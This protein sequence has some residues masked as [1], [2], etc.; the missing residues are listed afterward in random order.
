M[1]LIFE[2]EILKKE[3]RANK[4]NKLYISG[5]KSFQ[6]F[7]E[8]ASIIQSVFETAR[9]IFCLKKNNGIFTFVSTIF[10]QKLLEATW[11]TGIA[12]DGSFDC[13]TMFG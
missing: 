2:N 1:P 9:Q 6:R 7:K 12:M 3:V 5:S 8:K 10:R 11:F 13:L 4:E